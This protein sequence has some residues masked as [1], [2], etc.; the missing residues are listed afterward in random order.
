[1]TSA[2]VHLTEE[3]TILLNLIKAK[4]SLPNK[5]DAMNF[6]VH[7]YAKEA[8]EPELRPEY[9]RKIKRLLKE[10]PIAYSSFAEMRK[11]HEGA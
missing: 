2:I 9:V 6:A 10:K 11:A 1:M 7:E 5:S 4:F 8:L 3:N